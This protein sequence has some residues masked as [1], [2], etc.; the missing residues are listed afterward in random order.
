M[1]KAY[2]TVDTQQKQKTYNQQQLRKVYKKK[3]KYR[4]KTYEHMKEQ[5]PCQYE[6]NNL[7][8]KHKPAILG[9]RYQ[10]L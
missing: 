2:T 8:Q 1:K 5:K 10:R 6:D 9:R 3:R 7:L 4:N